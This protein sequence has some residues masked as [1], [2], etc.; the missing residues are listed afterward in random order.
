MNLMQSQS[1]SYTPLYVYRR[2]DASGPDY[3]RCM[4][5]CVCVDATYGGYVLRGYIIF[6]IS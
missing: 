2:C 6:Q 5:V 4:D 1:K 3:D